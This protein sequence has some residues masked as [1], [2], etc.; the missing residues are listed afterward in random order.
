[1]TTHGY[2]KF[3][4]NIIGFLICR[5]NAA[6]IFYILF[7]DL[8]KWTLKSLSDNRRKYILINFYTPKAKRANQFLLETNCICPNRKL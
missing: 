5:S 2:V 3:D 7:I 8:D 4:W 6:K 1:M